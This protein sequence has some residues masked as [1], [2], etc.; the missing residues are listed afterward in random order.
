MSHFFFF[1]VIK[2]RDAMAKPWAPRGPYCPVH[3][4]GIYMQYQT[5][6]KTKQDKTKTKPS[7]CQISCTLPRYK[8]SHHINRRRIEL[9]CIF[10]FFF[11]FFITRVQDIPM[12][13]NC[14]V[15]NL[16]PLLN[17]SSYDGA[18]VAEASSHPIYASHR[19]FFF[20]FL[21]S[22][23]ACS[24]EAMARLW[25]KPLLG[26]KRGLLVIGR[27][28]SKGARSTRIEEPE[29]E[30]QE[31]PDWYTFQL[32]IPCCIKIRRITRRGIIGKRSLLLF[33]IR[34]KFKHRTKVSFC[35]SCFSL[36]FSTPTSPFSLLLLF[37]W[38]VCHIVGEMQSAS[39][40]GHETS[41]LEPGMFLP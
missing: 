23:L 8:L 12:A 39:R 38:R 30:E 15:L 35:P 25:A 36:S 3:R 20:F 5:K 11:F 16:L 34:Q 19:T 10:F 18:R 17:P 26:L 2:I 9:Y 37:K 41:R 40:S 1:F 33:E 4:Q 7:I 21:K 29:V 13:R 31:G 27:R 28:L 32:N 14:I 22:I 24:I 6:E